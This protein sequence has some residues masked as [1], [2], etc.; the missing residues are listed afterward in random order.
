MS[1]EQKLSARKEAVRALSDAL[2]AE[3]DKWI[4]R[5]AFF[6]DS[7]YRYMR[8]LVS[9][10]L[11]VLDLGCGTGRLL[12]ELRPS[13]GVGVDISA[14]M[15]G[16]AR[17]A[18]PHLEFHVGD[19]EDVEFIS[20][21]SGPFDVIVLSDTIGSIEDCQGTLTNL[22]RLCTP[23]TRIVVAYYSK[24][25][26]PILA[27]AKLIGLKM[28]QTEQNA[29]STED[30]ENLLFLS[31]FETVKREWRQLIPRKLLGIGTVINRF[32][33]PF[34]V[35]RR[36]C[37][38]N[39]IVARP[40]AHGRREEASATVLIPCRNERGNVE[41]AVR[42]IPK[43]CKDMEILF[44]EGHSKDG[45]LEEIRRVIAAY[46]HLDIKV[47]VQDGE[48]KG[49][50]VRK[51]FENARGEILMVLDADLTVPPEALP[52]FYEA[53]ASGK[54]EFINGSRLVYPMEK[55]AMRF[56]NYLANHVFSWLFTWLLNQRFTDTLC[57]T[58]VL[59]KRHY[60]R[61]VE[62]RRYFGDFDP[63][64]DFD[65]IFGASKINLKVVEIP[66]AYGSRRYGET[67]ILRFQHGLLL[68]RMVVFAF[69]KLK[70]F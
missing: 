18:Y 36:A 6:Y 9:E 42:R 56:L 20:S 59:R 21:L 44:I 53:I 15:I 64:G 58:K 17:N 7:D 54:G 60:A 27:V 19:V 4:A 69:K 51:G 34:P 8:F 66:V 10:G 68:L 31:D 61:I 26:E 12:A 39:Y 40:M 29:L 55:D 5:N 49:D 11:R 22:H 47:L 65:L 2:A 13:V 48:G 16:V 25:W 46:P 50:A 41:E 38:R 30:I 37:L 35:I 52:K 28:P 33:A 23:D 63:F 1:N 67:Q 14:R 70:A 24:M 57:G 32:I 3:R 62:N 43:F 45:T